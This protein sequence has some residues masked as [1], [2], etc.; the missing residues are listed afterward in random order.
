L[1]PSLFDAANVVSEKFDPGSVL[2]RQAPPDGAAIS[3]AVLFAGLP[4][5]LHHLTGAVRD[6]RNQSSEFIV[7][8]LRGGEQRRIFLD[9]HE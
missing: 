6:F 5:R 9:D 1:K 4:Q 2:I 7:E 8:G 3:P